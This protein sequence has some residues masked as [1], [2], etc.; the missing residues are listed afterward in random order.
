LFLAWSYAI[1]ARVSTSCTLR[2]NT[3]A[4]KY[5]NCLSGVLNMRFVE[6][7]GEDGQQPSPTVPTV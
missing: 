4:A 3:G 6:V 2:N 7:R 5:T 1:M